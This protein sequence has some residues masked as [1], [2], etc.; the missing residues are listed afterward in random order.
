MFEYEPSK[1]MLLNFYTHN[2]KTDINV[3]VQVS[4]TD[5]YDKEEQINE[6]TLN[7]E[8]DVV[9]IQQVAKDLCKSEAGENCELFLRLSNKMSVVI[10]ITV[11]LMVK[12]SIIELKDGIWNS[13]QINA[14]AENTNFYFLP[15]NKNRSIT[16]LYRS[17][18]VD[19]KV[20]YTLWK[21][22]DKSINPAEW[23]FPQDY[24]AAQNPAKLAFA[25]TRFIHVD[26][27][28]LKG[29]WP[30]CVLLVSTFK[31][32]KSLKSVYGN[33]LQASQFKIMASSNFIEIPEKQ[34]IDVILKKEETK[35]LLID[36]KYVL[37]KEAVTIFTYFTIGSVQLSGNVY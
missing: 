27:G 4:T 32:E 8:S 31:D 9:D 34:K 33:F 13:Y 16:I 28:A 12:D 10:D 25:P 1:D 30:N 36:L 15:K 23:P 37:E 26:S 19:L 35:H 14:I 6:Y 17:D 21:T 5:E 20:M 2:M 7:V 22:D 11:T 3:L 18:F 24:K 29:C